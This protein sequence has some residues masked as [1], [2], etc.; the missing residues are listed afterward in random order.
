MI[1]SRRGYDYSPRG[2]RDYAVELSLR[3]INCSTDEIRYLAIVEYNAVNKIIDS[4]DVA[5]KWRQVIPDSIGEDLY[6]IVC[7]SKKK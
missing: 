3:E 1:K 6:N 7:K 2:F 4:V 5:G